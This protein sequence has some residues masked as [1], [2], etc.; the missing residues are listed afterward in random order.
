MFESADVEKWHAGVVR[1]AFV[2]QNVQKHRMFGPLLLKF[3][4]MAPRCGAKPMCKSK[5]TKTPAFW[6]TFGASDVEKVSNRRD[7]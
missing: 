6:H 7:R 4:K 1:S 3:R 5:C 2:S